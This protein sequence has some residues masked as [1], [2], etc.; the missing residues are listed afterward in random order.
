MRRR[1]LTDNPL[2]VF[3]CCLTIPVAA[4]QQPAAAA[5]VDAAAAAAAGAGAGVD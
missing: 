1:G 3:F 4:L 2:A 5:D